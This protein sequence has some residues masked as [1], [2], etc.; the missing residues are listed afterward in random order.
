MVVFF[1]C[2]PFKRKLSKGNTHV[3]LEILR[4]SALKSWDVEGNQAY[5]A[6][7]EVPS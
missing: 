7:K 1:S 5:F 2:V 3:H 6:G 4:S